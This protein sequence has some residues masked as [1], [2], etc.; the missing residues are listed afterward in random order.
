[1]PWL[2]TTVPRLLKIVGE[3]VWSSEKFV[4]P[5]TCVNVAPGSL[6]SA[7]MDIL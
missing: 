7:R 4:E 5:A 1:M 3:L 6:F 2:T